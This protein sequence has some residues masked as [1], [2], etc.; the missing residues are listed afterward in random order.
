[1]TIRIASR[2]VALTLVGSAFWA[3]YTFSLGEFYRYSDDQQV[4][5]PRVVSIGHSVSPLMA[6]LGDVP[7]FTIS[8]S[9]DLSYKDIMRE[10]EPQSVAIK[11]TAQ[12][13]E[14]VGDRSY[15]PEPLGPPARPITV[16]LSS[17]TFD[18][19]PSDTITTAEGTSLPLRFRWSA[20][21]QR[22]GDNELLLDLRDL[23]AFPRWVAGMSDN[24]PNFDFFFVNGELA[25]QADWETRALPVVVNNHLGIPAWLA[26]VLMA[27][28]GLAGFVLLH[29]STV[30]W[31]DAR[32]QSA[33]RSSPWKKSVR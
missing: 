20:A 29:P 8:A 2:V 21:P 3:Y 33:R 12:V 22:Q 30:A 6:S 13:T 27:M 32:I 4:A 9:I 15:P 31:L 17:A 11:Y 16:T 18:I 14:I 10:D 5:P 26:N 25:E 24:S 28:V 1:M 19:A 7:T 23:L